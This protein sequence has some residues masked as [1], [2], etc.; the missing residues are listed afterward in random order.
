MVSA[1]RA[2]AR[3]A[4]RAAPGAEPA[5]PR[6]P[7]PRVQE[8]RA[9]A[10]RG[11]HGNLPARHDRRGEAHAPARPRAAPRRAARREEN[12]VVAARPAARR[13]GPRRSAARSARSARAAVVAARPAGSLRAPRDR[14]R[15]GAALGLAAQ[16]EVQEARQRLGA[17][18]TAADSRDGGRGGVGCRAPRTPP[19]S[20]D[21][22][23][24]HRRTGSPPA[25][26]SACCI[27]PRP[28]RGLA[29]FSEHILASS[30]VA[31]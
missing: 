19:T 29:A 13:E 8:R 17:L 14:R 1:G 30:Q 3:G 16:E 24:I 12:A 28:R 31:A 15:R 5:D 4:R 27:P 18:P 9:A 21:A 26:L 6:F 20:Q 25:Y 2:V 23:R 10:A 11:D 7:D 22:L